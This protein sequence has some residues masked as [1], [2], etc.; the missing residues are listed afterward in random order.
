[1]LKYTCSQ[2]ITFDIWVH[3]ISKAEDQA[4]SFTQGLL[5]LATLTFAKVIVS[6]SIFTFTQVLTLG[7]FYNVAQRWQPVFGVYIVDIIYR[8]SYFHESL[9]V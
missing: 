4:E 5:V 6:Y 9:L 2:N 3:L 1:M 7:R 8:P